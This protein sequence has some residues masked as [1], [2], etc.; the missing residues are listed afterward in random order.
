MCEL[1]E[2]D[3]AD[4]RRQEMRESGAMRHIGTM[5]DTAQASD[6]RAPQGSRPEAENSPTQGEHGT[7]QRRAAEGRTCSADPGASHLTAEANG[8]LMQ[9]A[10]HSG[11]DW[12]TLWGR[13]ASPV[14][15]IYAAVVVAC[16]SCAW[17]VPAYLHELV[18]GL[19]QQM[20]ELE[21][22]LHPG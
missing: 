10:E 9:T 1:L 6:G 16:A 21:T 5:Q 13:K 20:I 8:A 11:G 17:L 4:L 2:Q 22:Q 18:L 19:E 15:P 12:Y 7:A 3:V 14:H